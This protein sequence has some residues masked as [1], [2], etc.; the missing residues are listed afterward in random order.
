MISIIQLIRQPN[1]INIPYSLSLFDCIFLT[2]IP[3]LQ[4]LKLTPIP[5]VQPIPFEDAVADED[6]KKKN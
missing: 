1:K 3:A 2:G 5:A 4:P 6:W